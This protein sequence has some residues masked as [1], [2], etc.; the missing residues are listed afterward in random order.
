MQDSLDFGR[1]GI[2]QVAIGSGVQGNG[3]PTDG[4]VYAGVVISTENTEVAY[5][6][7]PGHVLDPRG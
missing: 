5:C 2:G 3:D 7:G 6:R 4:K 1:P